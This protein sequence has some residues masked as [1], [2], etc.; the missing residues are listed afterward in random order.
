M[1]LL[2]EPRKALMAA[3]QVTEAEKAILSRGTCVSK[4]H[5]G[6]VQRE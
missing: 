1:G 4:A 3:C 6:S 5:S 2:W